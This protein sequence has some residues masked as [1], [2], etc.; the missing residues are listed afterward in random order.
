METVQ[1]GKIYKHYKGNEYRVIGVGKHTET[2]EDFVVYQSPEGGQIWIRPVVMF[3][4][5]VEWQGN[6]VPRFSL[7]GVR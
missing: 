4:E 5:V 2:G 6:K 3:F 7:I 1:P